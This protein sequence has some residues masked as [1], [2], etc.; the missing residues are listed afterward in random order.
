[1]C[2]QDSCPVFAKLNSSSRLS[3]LG[4]TSAGKIQSYTPYPTS[5]APGMPPYPTTPSNFPSLPHGNVG[6]VQPEHLKAS[7]MS[8]VEHKI[9]QR[10][11]EKL[12]NF[13]F[14]V[15][16]Y[17]FVLRGTLKNLG[18]RSLLLKSELNCEVEIFSEVF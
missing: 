3:G 11:R 16:N 6:T 2:F 4:S 18:S 5:N 15:G 9:R 10:L 12:G 17:F 13:L 14:L 7:V 1:M 8:A